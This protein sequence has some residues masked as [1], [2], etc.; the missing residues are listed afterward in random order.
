MVGRKERSGSKREKEE[1][2]ASTRKNQLKPPMGGAN[3]KLYEI[4]TLVA[5]GALRSG[6]WCRRGGAQE[7]MRC[8]RAGLFRLPLRLHRRRPRPQAPASQ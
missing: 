8:G 2:S 4:D 5:S 6:H 1:E 3:Q 7:G